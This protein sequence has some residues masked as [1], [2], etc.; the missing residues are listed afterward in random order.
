MPDE[1]K[2]DIEAADNPLWKAILRQ[3]TEIE[4]GSFFVYF[5]VHA[6]KPRNAEIGDIRKRIREEQ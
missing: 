1:H 5:K 6:G 3:A 2:K 4:F